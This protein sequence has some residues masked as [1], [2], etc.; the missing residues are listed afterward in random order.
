M[1]QFALL[2][3]AAGAF[4]L[5]G[6]QSPAPQKTPATGETVS[7]KKG[8]ES[9]RYRCAD[10]TVVEATYPDSDTAQIVY[11]GQSITM[12][13]A[14]SA[15][16]ARYTGGGWEWWTKGLK[17]GTLTPLPPGKDIAP[18]TGVTCTVGTGEGH[19]GSHE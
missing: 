12:K 10:G 13:V 1:K 15:S 3:V 16:G 11:Q 9:T 4:L 8:A 2:Y 5:A 14:V 19:S 6:C 7:A 17:E 18:P